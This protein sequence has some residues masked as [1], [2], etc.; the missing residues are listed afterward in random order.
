MQRPTQQALLKDSVE[1]LV[2]QK[3]TQFPK[4]PSCGDPSVV[5]TGQR[6]VTG[7]VA[8][9]TSNLGTLGAQIPST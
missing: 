9:T 7:S 6:G 5:L 3:G 1:L 8:N 2:S 4:A